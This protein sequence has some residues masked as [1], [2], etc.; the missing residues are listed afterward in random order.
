MNPPPLLPAALPGLLEY[1][2]PLREL[3]PPHRRGVYLGVG[4]VAWESPAWLD[5]HP[6]LG[7]LGLDLTERAGRWRAA[8][9]LI[10]TAASD[11]RCRLFTP[12][13][14]ELLEQV[15]WGETLDADDI[16]ELRALVLTTAHT[17]GLMRAGRVL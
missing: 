5:I 3:A 6:Q 4:L 12:A 11:A 8:T 14:S 15:R 7:D 2:A 1:G 10:G 9:W 17:V 13:E 16:S